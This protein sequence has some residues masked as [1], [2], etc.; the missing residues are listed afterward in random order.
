[1]CVCV[2]VFVWCARVGAKGAA[3]ALRGSRQLTSRSRT[4]TQVRWV[5]RRGRRMREAGEKVERDERR[6]RKR[7]FAVE[8]ETQGNAGCAGTRP[9][10]GGQK[11]VT[12]NAAHEGRDANVYVAENADGIARGSE[13]KLRE[14]MPKYVMKQSQNISYIM[15]F[16]A[17]ACFYNVACLFP[18]E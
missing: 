8:K 9:W 14:K 2:C 1:M 7:T 10:T 6:G 13:F 18:W 11:N 15:L 3:D 17:M 4:G 12:G 16:V 5:V